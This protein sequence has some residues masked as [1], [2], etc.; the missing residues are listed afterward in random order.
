MQSSCPGVSGAVL[1]IVVTSV[2][3]DD[4]VDVRRLFWEQVYLH[5]VVRTLVSVPSLA[6]A[7]SVP[8]CSALLRVGDLVAV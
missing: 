1:R 6:L 2:S 7:L 3:G 8:W 4:C 5:G